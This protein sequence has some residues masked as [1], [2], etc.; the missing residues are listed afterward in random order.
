MNESMLLEQRRQA[1]A[2]K[3]LADSALLDLHRKA[4]NALLATEEGAQ[5]RERAL[6]QVEKWHRQHLCNPRYVQAWRN[7]LD[8]PVASIP[9][10]MLREDAEGVALRQNSPFGFMLNEAAAA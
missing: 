7:I 5:V 8:L 2:A 1:R 4:A 9:A 6:R 3:H 10:A